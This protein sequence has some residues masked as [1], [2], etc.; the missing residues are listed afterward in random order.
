MRI[1][2]DPEKLKARNLTTEDVVAAIQEQNV[3]VAAGQIGQPPA[4]EGPDLSVH[5]HDAGPAERPRAVREH[6]RQ[7]DAAARAAR[8]TRVKDVARVELGA[9]A[10]DQLFEVNG[11]PAAGLAV[12]QLP[13]ANALDVADASARRWSEL[14]SR[15]PEGID[16]SIPFDTTIFV[17]RV[18]PRGLQDAVR[19][20]RP[21]ADRDPGLPAGLA[22]RADPGDDR[23]GDDHRRL[24]GDVC[25]WASRS[26]C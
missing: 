25:A 9:Q 18:D 8:I 14:K 16:Y 12:F 1:W 3:Q 15:F 7:D 5:G 23:A 6:H 2:L 10:Y 22:G 17:E 19:G 11:K 24:R 20:R 21:R 13:G 26:T 4:P